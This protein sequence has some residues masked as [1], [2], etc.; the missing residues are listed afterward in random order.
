M[1]KPVLNDEVNKKQ[2]SDLMKVVEGALGVPVELDA[3]P[4]TAGGE[5]PFN[6]DSGWYSGNLYINLGGTVRRISYTNV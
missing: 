3:A 2:D 5:L 1:R 6:G 4:T